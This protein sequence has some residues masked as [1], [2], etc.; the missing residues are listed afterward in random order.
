MDALEEADAPG[1]LRGASG[2]HRL[3]GDLDGFWAVKVSRNWRIWFRF[4]GGD[5]W[6]VTLDDYH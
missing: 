2:L 6:D 4:E 5:V 3:G 1:N